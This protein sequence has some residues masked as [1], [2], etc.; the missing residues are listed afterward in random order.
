MEKSK[1]H[2]ELVA[3]ILSEIPEDVA[4]EAEFPSQGKFYTPIDENEPI[5]IR[6]LTFEDEKVLAN[7][8][9]K[10][11]VEIINTIIRR[12]VSNMDTN[13]LL[14]MDKVYILVTIRSISFG[15]GFDTSITC[16]NCGE[17]TRTSIDLSRL[18]VN[19]LPKNFKNPRKVTLPVCKRDAVVIFP[20]SRDEKYTRNINVASKNIWR[21]VESINGINDKKIIADVIE[22]LPLMDIKELM[23]GIGGGNYGIETSFIFQ[24]PDDY[25]GEES[26]MEVPFDE[27][28]F[29]LS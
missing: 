16:P 3:D 7:L 28:F 11:G 26:L 22:K 9:I 8:K 6:P 4:V 5:T 14:D 17:V 15:S 23:A 21:F 25:C 20:R 13:D 24:C 29:T 12:C 19:K 1:S 2:E 10:S 18:G 27:D